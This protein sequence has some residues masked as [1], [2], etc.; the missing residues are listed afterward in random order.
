MKKAILSAALLF[1]FSLTMFLGTTYA[2]FSETIVVSN[3]AIRTGTFD[4]DFLIADVE[5]PETWYNLDV[6]GSKI[7]DNDYLY[8]GYCDGRLL[9][10]TNTGEIDVAFTIKTY[11]GYWTNEAL[12]DAITF[13]VEGIGSS[14]YF[15]IDFNEYLVLRPGETVTFAVYYQISESLGNI[16]QEQWL[17]FDLKLEAIQVGEAIQ[18]EARLH[19][20]VE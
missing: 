8:P 13:T 3:N 7:F 19:Y 6:E 18:R 10:V 14:K 16:G 1:V 4:V 17:T 12:K 20:L 11:N 5:E 2:W 15:D 9:K